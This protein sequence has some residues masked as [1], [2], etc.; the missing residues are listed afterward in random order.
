MSLPKL[1]HASNLFKGLGTRKLELVACYE[2]PE[3]KPT[4]EA[5]IAVEGYSEISARSYL[6]AIDAFWLWAA[7]LPVEII[8]YE[9]LTDWSNRV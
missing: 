3:N 1:Q 9:K 6:S 4:L 7:E 5:L 2:S 8:P